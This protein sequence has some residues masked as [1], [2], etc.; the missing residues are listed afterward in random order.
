MRLRSISA[1]SPKAKAFEETPEHAIGKGNGDRDGLINPYVNFK[2]VMLCKAL[3]FIALIFNGL[4][5][6]GDA[7]VGVVHKRRSFFVRMMN[8][9]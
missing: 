3:N 2:V 8:Y 4:T 7:D 5:V 6:G 1:E 9:E